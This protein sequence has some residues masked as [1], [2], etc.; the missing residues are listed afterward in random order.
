MLRTTHARHRERY[1]IWS[2][3]VG[4]WLVS[5]VPREIHDSPRFGRVEPSWRLPCQRHPFNISFSICDL[6]V[7]AVMWDSQTGTMKDPRQLRRYF[8]RFPSAERTAMTYILS[9]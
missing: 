2:A 8:C 3:Q 9:A 6:L 1:A 7:R 4:A 5:E